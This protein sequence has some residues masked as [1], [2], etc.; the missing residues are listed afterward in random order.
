M[1]IW[2]FFEGVLAGSGLFR[3][4]FAGG[5][6]LLTLRRF[7]AFDTSGDAGDAK[8]PILVP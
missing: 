4:R 8:N 7:R 1:R 2:H 3:S 5:V 6:S